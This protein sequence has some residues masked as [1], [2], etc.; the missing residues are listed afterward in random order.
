MLSEDGEV[1]FNDFNNMVP[2][3]WNDRKGEYCTFWAH[4]PGTFKAPEVYGGGH[5]VTEQVDIW[6]LG[7]LIFS[8]LT[9]LRPWYYLN[10]ESEIQK[11][12][13]DNG[14]PY[15]DPRYR[16]RSFIERRLVDIM[17]KCHKLDSEERPSI[18][19]IVEFL[20]ETK[21]I[22]EQTRGRDDSLQRSKRKESQ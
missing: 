1:I 13:I 4:Y 19:E 17:A 15:I 11:T 22:H 18:F 6:P 2:M 14:A 20:R 3:E 7:N 9:G 8:L 16:K 10:E 21:H 5:Y 12:M